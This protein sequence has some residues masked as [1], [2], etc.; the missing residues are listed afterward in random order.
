[1]WKGLVRSAVAQSKILRG[2]G[3]AARHLERV[4]KGHKTK[5]KLEPNTLYIQHTQAGQGRFEPSLTMSLIP[6]DITL[7]EL[8]AK[9]HAL[10]VLDGL[11]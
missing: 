9:E 8:I 1:M 2:R 10:K 11:L 6:G 4:Q 3:S 5:L 7:S